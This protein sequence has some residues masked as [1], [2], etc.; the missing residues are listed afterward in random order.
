[1]GVLLVDSHRHG[2]A[3]PSILSAQ[4]IDSMPRTSHP[5]RPSQLPMLATSLQRANVR[6]DS[7]QQY[8]QAG[9]FGSMHPYERREVLLDFHLLH[10]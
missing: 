3:E 8:L 6:L 7:A 5:I 4:D 1:M 9:L 10:A 2:K